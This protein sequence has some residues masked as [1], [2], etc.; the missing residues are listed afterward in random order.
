VSAFWDDLA[1]ELSNDDFVAWFIEACEGI[2]NL[3]IG[4]VPC[5]AP[6]GV[7]FADGWHAYACAY[8]GA[9]L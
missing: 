1:M 6:H 3:E 5:E 2:A 4:L 7:E 9:Q 8:C